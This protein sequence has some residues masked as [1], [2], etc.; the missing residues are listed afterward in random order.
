LWAFIRAAEPY[1]L[2]L[3]DQKSQAVER[4]REVLE[5]F[6]WYWFSYFVA[7]VVPGASGF[8]EEALSALTKG[9]ANDTENMFLLSALAL[10]HGRRGERAEA[11]RIL[12]QLEET[13]RMRYVSPA[14]FAI[15]AMGCADV[16][17]TYDWLNK[18]VDEH[19]P[20]IIVVST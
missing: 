8:R 5:L 9:L 1:A 10:I 7:A 14:A 18:A 11:I 19:D 13:A 6:P 12:Q 16:E 20:M 4:A 15:A 3:R 2:L 17:R